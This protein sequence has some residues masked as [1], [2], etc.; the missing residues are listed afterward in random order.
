[1][2]ELK[3]KFKVNKMR[4]IL[5]LTENIMSTKRKKLLNSPYLEIRLKPHPYLVDSFNYLGG[6]HVLLAD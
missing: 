2:I 5:M 3:N 1:M 4:L 6:M